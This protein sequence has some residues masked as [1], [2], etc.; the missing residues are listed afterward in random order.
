MAPVHPGCHHTGAQKKQQ[1]SKGSS[2]NQDLHRMVFFLFWSFS[3]HYR[4]SL[5][6]AVFL[7]FL[8]KKR[9]DVAHG[10]D[11]TVEGVLLPVP[12]CPQIIVPFLH[13]S[14]DLFL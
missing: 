13:I 11:G 10:I 8:F 9:A 7:V 2:Q 6:A 14:N 4:L 3:R 12:L 5:S 1:D